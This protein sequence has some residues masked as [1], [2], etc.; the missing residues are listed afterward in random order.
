MNIKE[1]LLTFIVDNQNLVYKIAEKFSSHFDIEDLVQAGNIGFLKA[2]KNY[3]ES[4]GVKFS[5]YAYNYIKGSILEFVKENHPIK[6]T[7]EVLALNKTI[8]NAKS[9]LTQKLMREPT[10]FE[11]SLFLEMDE[12]KI[13]EVDLAMSYVDSLDR[14]VKEGEK[15]L[16]LIDVVGTNDNRK[17]I[18]I[19]M[20]KD[21]IE[22]LTKEEKTL[23]LYRYYEDM[24]QQET[25]DILGL[26][27]V[28]IS[29]GE[30]K[31]LKKMRNNFVK[32]A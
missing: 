25:A 22:K 6:I 17:D 32:N 31:I 15:E 24:T 2:A 10:T 20:L 12:T 5:S 16:Q 29:R 19:L 23:L 9:Y 18:D 30:T 1:E 27:Q 11:L 8:E 14:T 28:Q 13:I 3:D 7:K 26:S 4:Y 21:E